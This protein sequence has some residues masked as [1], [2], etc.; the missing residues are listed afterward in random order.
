MEIQV[1][2]NEGTSLSHKLCPKP[3]FVG[4]ETKPIRGDSFQGKPPRDGGLWGMMVQSNSKSM[5]ESGRYAQITI[6]TLI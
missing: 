4:E 5:R 3:S 6:P 1:P 2:S